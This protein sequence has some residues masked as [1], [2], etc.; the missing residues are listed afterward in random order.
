MAA[1]RE[2]LEVV[3][4]ATAP[5]R[6]IGTEFSRTSQKAANL[7]S[8][9][10]RTVAA[11]A[12]L[13]TVK[14]T[15]N[16]SDQLALT[17]AR[18][19]NVNDGLQTTEELQRMIF[20]SAQRARGNYQQ[21]AQ[22][23]ANLKAQ[24]GDTFSSI[25][26]TVAFTELLNKQFKIAGTDAT[27]ISSV[28]YNLTQALATGVLRG[29]DLNIVMSN[30]PQI[31]QRI[32]RYMGVS[33]GELRK[34]AE[35]GQITSDVVKN[36]IMGSAEDIENQFQKIP[37]T[38]SDSMQKLKNVGLWLFRPIGDM[39]NRGINSKGF[40][41]AMNGIATGIAYA[42]NLAQRGFGLIGRGIEYVRNNMSTFGPIIA[43]A[44]AGMLFY[45]ASTGAAA[46]ASALL[47]NPLVLI[48]ALLGYIIGYL[49]NVADTGH[50]T[51][52]DLAGSALG[53]YEAM[54][55]GIKIAGNFILSV[56]EGIA[57]GWNNTIFTIK[58]A[59]WN[60]V[61]ATVNGVN[62]LVDAL[63]KI[64]G[65]NIGAV[66]NPLEMPDQKERVQFERFETTSMSD[67]FKSGYARGANWGDQKQN[68]VMDEFADLN[69]NVT[70]LMGGGSFGD[71]M[72]AME[73]NKPL[74]AGDKVNVG[75]VDKVKDVKLS[76]EDVALYRD[77]AERRYMNNI[78]LKT[79]AP[80]ISV[81]VDGAEA[82]NLS[83]QDIADKLKALLIEQQAAHTAVA[84][85]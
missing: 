79:L 43:G 19:N 23:V 26:E 37:A 6:R 48:G 61:Q 84:H 8:T 5:L 14:A 24:T 52:G 47:A 51:F 34:M 83:A 4:R 67:A 73:A 56:A 9:V 2:V 69:K 40:E 81:K 27:Q 53:A 28:M 17:E 66:S 29:Q 74:G 18:L 59:F 78:E 75:S 58:N 25:R 60:F 32:A 10:T 80:N 12:T 38:F 15:L 85:G 16:I 7:G 50:T 65:I 33:V 41:Q 57:N 44:A 13:A 72:A 22:T 36:A 45:A 63:N 68:A 70:E 11:V 35:Q 20:D 54:M 82:R 46:V 31:A 49:H 71:F 30:A 3:D 76:D 1:I 55:N 39:I 64:P 21:M 77:L 62:V 42:A